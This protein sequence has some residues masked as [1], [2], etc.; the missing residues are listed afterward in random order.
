MR[1]FLLLLLAAC[2][3]AQDDDLERYWD[4]TPSRGLDLVVRSPYWQ[5]VA[6]NEPVREM[7]ASRDTDH[8][9]HRHWEGSVHLLN[10]ARILRQR[11][12]VWEMN[13]SPMYQDWDGYMGTT[14]RGPPS[15]TPGAAWDWVD[16]HR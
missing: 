4:C 7:N 6:N 10:R 11:P 13:P 12:W 1:F 5:R 15:A 3:A 2:A 16:T 14:P 9:W 8:D